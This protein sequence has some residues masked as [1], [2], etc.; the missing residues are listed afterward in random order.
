[1]PEENQTQPVPA[2]TPAPVVTPD[3]VPAA[4]PAATQDSNLSSWE[5]PE[6]KKAMEFDPFTPEGDEVQIPAATT[7]DVSPSADGGKVDPAQPVSEQSASTPSDS[8]PP[9]EPVAPVIS[10]ETKS[11]QDQVAQLTN[12]IQ[13]MQKAAP[14]P[15]STEPQQPQDPLEVMPDYQ[16]GLPDELMRMMA[17]EDPVER[18]TGTAH[19]VTG[20]ARSIHQTV[21]AAVGQR[22]KQLE[23]SIPNSINS[24]VQT[25][26]LQQTIAKDMYSKYPQLDN[27]QIR[28][29]VKAAYSK[30]AEQTGN[31]QWN[32]AVR[33]KVAQAV[34]TSLAGIIQPAPVAGQVLAV[35]VPTLLPPTYLNGGNA[36]GARPAGGTQPKSQQGHMADVF[37]TG[38]S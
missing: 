18:K 34:I 14:A 15:T 31:W 20:V 32:D 37:D 9:A 1:M 16:F 22:L 38:I 24:V 33:D 2:P 3:P 23:S 8:T 30:I 11:L 21:T 6:V 17:S 5:T 29:M 35:P 12:V 4:E 28:P 10:P 27:E 13:T 36:A 25:Q 26:Q 19:L 7:P